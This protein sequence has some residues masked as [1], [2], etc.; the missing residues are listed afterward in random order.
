MNDDQE[1]QAGLRFGVVSEVDPKGARARV[2]FDE[3]DGLET[4][5]LPVGQRKTHQDKD[6]WMPDVGEHVACLMDQYLEDGVILCAI[7]SDADTPPVA[8]ADVRMV[9]FRDGAE[10]A[11]NRKDGT[12]SV[13]G[14]ARVVVEA[15]SEIVLRAPRLVVD[16]ASVSFSGDVDVAGK[17]MDA[18]GN[19]N[20][21]SH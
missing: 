1:Q 16:A 17:L 21:H 9:R 5:L 12:L 8:D 10:M 14:V 19:S 20:H 11:Y 6:Y 2:R 3:L 15:G 4:A 18:G 13:R 7:Y